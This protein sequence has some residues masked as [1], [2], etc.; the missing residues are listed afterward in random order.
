MTQPCSSQVSWKFDPHVSP[1]DTRSD[2]GL[3]G[4][5]PADTDREGDDSLMWMIW[6]YP[7]IQINGVK[8]AR[9]PEQNPLPQVSHGQ[10]MHEL[11][12]TSDIK[13]MHIHSYAYEHINIYIYIYIYIYTCIHTHMYI[14]YIYTYMKIYVYIYACVCMYV[15]MYVCM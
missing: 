4:N 8:P 1:H 11:H 12:Q 5:M 14:Y 2:F 3:T 10:P 7:C 6:C 9:G 15:C 13:D